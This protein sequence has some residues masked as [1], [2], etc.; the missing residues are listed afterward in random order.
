MLI[1]L[2]FVSKTNVYEGKLKSHAGKFV[3][4]S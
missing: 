1:S 3:K 4:I 2:S